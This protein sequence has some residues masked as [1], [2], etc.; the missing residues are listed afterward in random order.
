MIPGIHIALG[1]GMIVLMTVI[2][3]IGLIG[4]ANTLPRLSKWAR[5]NCPRL[6]AGLLLVTSVIWLIAIHTLEVW[7]WALVYIQVG[8]FGDIASALYFSTVTATTLG[9]GDVVLSSD[10][11]LL[12]AFEAM[13]G[14]ILF[15]ASTAFLLSIMGHLFKQMEEK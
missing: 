4:L 5:H 13:G 9:F 14:L 7:I 2:H 12:S 15:G 10:W 11:Q 3:V 8:E 6:V 1:T